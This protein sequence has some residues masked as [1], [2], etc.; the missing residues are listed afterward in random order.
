MKVLNESHRHHTIAEI[1]DGRV[2]RSFLVSPPEEIAR[3]I[4]SLEVPQT[5]LPSLVSTLPPICGGVSLNILTGEGAAVDTTRV[6]K[7]ILWCEPVHTPS[8]FR[9]GNLPLRCGGQR[10]AR[11]EP[12]QPQENTA[13]T[14]I[15]ALF[16][17]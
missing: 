1:I 5:S 13:R 4:A 15:S 8:L 11:N 16:H 9:V 17:K 7:K 14:P 12:R 6:F 10:F 3:Q 2:V